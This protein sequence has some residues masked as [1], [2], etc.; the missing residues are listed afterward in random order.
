MTPLE[1]IDYTSQEIKQQPNLKEALEAS[2]KD[3]KITQEE[4]K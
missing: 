2:L 3:G 1:A 4:A